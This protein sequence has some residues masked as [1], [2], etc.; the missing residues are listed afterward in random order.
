MTNIKCP[1]VI[2]EDKVMNAQLLRFQLKH[3]GFDDVIHFTDAEDALDWL[4]NNTSSLVL[5]D[6]QMFPMEGAV[7][8]RKYREWE[9]TRNRHALVIAV[10]ASATA[11]DHENCL[12]AGVD[13]YLRKPL[14]LAALSETLKKWKLL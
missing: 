10:T 12:S 5:T 14:G 13:D 11:R 1:I 2:I 3:L 7:F 4:K 6:W 9:S 8:V